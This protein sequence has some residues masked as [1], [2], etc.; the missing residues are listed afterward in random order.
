[1]TAVKDVTQNAVLG[2][3]GKVP[4]TVK[5]VEPGKEEPLEDPKLLHLQDLQVT[6]DLQVTLLTHVQAFSILLEWLLWTSVKKGEK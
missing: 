6:P 4:I 1:V 5:S 3:P 2:L